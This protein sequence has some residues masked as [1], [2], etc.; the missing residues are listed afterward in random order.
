MP[1]PAHRP[2]AA[3]D[4]DQLAEGLV[5]KWLKVLTVLIFCSGLAGATTITMELV[6]FDGP[7]AGGANSGGGV[8][9]YPYYF[10]INGSSYPNLT[11]LI[12]DSYDN[13]VWQ[14]E[15][16]QADEVPL[17]SLFGQANAGQYKEAAWLFWN[18]GTD[19]SSHDAV[20]YNFAIWGLFSDNALHSAGYASSGASTVLSD[21]GGPPV[22]FNYSGFTVYKPVAGTQTLHG[23]SVT[24]LPQ[25]Y[26][27]YTPPSVPE[28]SSLLLLAVG[29]S[30]AAT[31][32]RKK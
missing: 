28:P 11:P 23:N 8:Y 3:R 16:W 24:N 21:A 1:V 19:P 18:M 12:C 2:I 9:A 7:T 6:R 30:L 15:S 22:N 25:E 29:M 31:R 26:I 5:T 17:S 13:E 27:G 32:V 4:G 10:S 20:A 14:N